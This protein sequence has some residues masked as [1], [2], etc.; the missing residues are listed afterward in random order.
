VEAMGAGVIPVLNDIGAFR[1]FVTDGEEGFIA[2]FSD[3]VAAAK[4]IKRARD[5]SKAARGRM[6]KA[7]RAR[8]TE[9]GW[10][11]SVCRFEELYNDVIRQWRDKNG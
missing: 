6:V 11:A 8:S 4:C 9:Y 10:D 1:H 5:L 3:K 2:D 7:T